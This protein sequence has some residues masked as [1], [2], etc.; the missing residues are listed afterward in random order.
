[1]AGIAENP[2]LLPRVERYIKEVLTKWPAILPDATT[3]QGVWS[4]RTDAVKVGPEKVIAVVAEAVDRHF[5]KTEFESKRVRPSGKLPIVPSTGLQIRS[6]AH[7]FGAALAAEIVNNS[8]VWLKSN[9][10]KQYRPEEWGDAGPEPKNHARWEGR[11]KIPAE[12]ERIA[13]VRG[14]LLAIMDSD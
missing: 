6:A 8:D 1:L 7:L 2:K 12:F 11:Q 4:E 3:L 13:K 9:W 5:P 14:K 10:E